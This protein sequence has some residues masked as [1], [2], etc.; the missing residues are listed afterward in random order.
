MAVLKNFAETFGTDF[1]N[2]LFETIKALIQP[3]FKKSINPLK[4]YYKQFK[5]EKKARWLMELIHQNILQKK[6]EILR[7]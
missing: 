2:N 6:K 4:Q 3:F 7:S 5:K 1:T